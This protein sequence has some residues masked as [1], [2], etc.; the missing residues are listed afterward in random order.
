MAKY[1]TKEELERDPLAEF[2]G[3]ASIF[4][5]QNKT[6]ILSASVTVLVVAA[7]LIGYNL[8]SSK[9]ETKAQILLAQAENFYSEGD[10]YT[11]LNGD[12]VTFTPGFVEIA[13]DYSGTNA[14]NLAIYYASVSSYKLGNYE[15][16]LAYI[17]K[18]KHVK[19]IL[20]VSSLSF[21][22]SLYELNKEYEKAAEVYEKAAGWD[23]NDSTTP[24]NLYKAANAYYHAG[25]N[26]KAA[27]AIE[28]IVNEYPES[29]EL[30]DSQ[31][32]QGILLA[33][34]SGS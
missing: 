3:K 33:S 4:Y 8:Y 1:H 16:A 2:I 28:R 7:V 32:L 24:Y 17:K 9:Q 29:D 10:Y 30:A 27:R 13:L 22:A 6:M 14:G 31:R 23:E 12:E 26:S 5:S 25:D 19:G 21:E 18:Y 11:A 20:G 15:D 34:G